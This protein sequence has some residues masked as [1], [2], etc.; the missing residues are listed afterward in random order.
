MTLE[1]K[2]AAIDTEAVT[3]EGFISGYASRFN[4]KDQGGDIVAPGAYTKSLEA[5][6]MPAMLWQHD[7]AQPIGYWTSAVEDEI[8]LKLEGQIITDFPEGKRAY[9]LAK[10]GA[11]KGLS[12]GYITKKSERKG[13]ARLLTELDLWEVSMVTFPM[14]REASI[15]A[16]K[17]EDFENQLLAAKSGDFT[18]LKRAVEGALRDAGFPAWM[19]K[20]Q[21][22][23]APEAL[24]DGQ[25]D[26]AGSAEI[27]K[28]LRD[29]FDF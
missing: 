16:V 6:G 15:D 24:T 11:M 3:E 21:A 7:P 26:A 8:G 5:R 19:A 9:T 2:Y 29:S 22:A 25:R 13:S 20:A 1:M 23:R 17:A 4:L 12:I 10:R 27:A 18:P 14:Q 28:L